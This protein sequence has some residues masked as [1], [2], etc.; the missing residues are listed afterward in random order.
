MA[1]AR[2]GREVS[3]ERIGR[4]ILAV[5]VGALVGVPLVRLLILVGVEGGPAL[6]ALAGQQRT[7]SAA[8]GTLLTAGTAVMLS[9]IGGL[10]RGGTGH[11]LGTIVTLA[12]AIPARP[13]RSPSSWPTVRGSGTPYSSS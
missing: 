7:L 3:W 12:F 13:S 4:W 1:D 9:L 8:L 5:G 6:E 2:R 11:R 10:A